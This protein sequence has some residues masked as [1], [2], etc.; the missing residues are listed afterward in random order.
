[1]KILVVDDS[2]L[3]RASIIKTLNE[4][5]DN[6]NEIIQ[7]TNGQEAV[8]LYQTHT[9]DILFLDLTMPVM[10]GFEALRQIRAYDDKA[11]VVIVSADIQ[12]KAVS[13]VMHDGAIMHVQ[14]PINAKKMQEIIKTASFLSK[15]ESSHE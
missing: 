6:I 10:D 3:A 15:V 11:H 4:A 13:Q 5:F 1:M 14:K 8:E 9:P 12:E 2:R 7:G